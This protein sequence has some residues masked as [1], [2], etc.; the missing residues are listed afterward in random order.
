MKERYKNV[1]IHVKPYPHKSHILS[2]K[3][4]YLKFGCDEFETLV[5]AQTN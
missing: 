4:Y 1:Q 3:R 2:V 5:F